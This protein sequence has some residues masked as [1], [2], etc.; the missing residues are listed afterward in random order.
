MKRHKMRTEYKKVLIDR[1]GR[2]INL[3]KQMT[4]GETRK[5]KTSEGY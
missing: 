4:G 3:R 5:P 2:M 1:I